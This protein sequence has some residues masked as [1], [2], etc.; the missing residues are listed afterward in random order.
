MVWIA[1]V[2]LGVWL[3]SDAVK[4]R[5]LSGD[6]WQLGGLRCLRSA[7][8]SYLGDDIASGKLSWRHENTLLPLKGVL[9]KFASPEHRRVN[10]VP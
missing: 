6:D 9:Y 8:M 7:S 10:L 2:M 3:T 1:S 5:R 4:Y